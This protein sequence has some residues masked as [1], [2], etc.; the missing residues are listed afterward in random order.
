M[1]R[2]N[3]RYRRSRS[4]VHPI[5]PIVPLGRNCGIVISHDRIIAEWRDDARA[6]Y[7]RE[8]REGCEIEMIVVAVRY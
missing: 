6:M 7:G 3:K 5:V 8:L 4:D 2:R 1:L